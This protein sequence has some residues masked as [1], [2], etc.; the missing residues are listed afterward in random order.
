MGRSGTPGHVLKLLK[1]GDILI[2]LP[3][4]VAELYALLHLGEC[5]LEHLSEVA[6]NFVYSLLQLS[7]LFILRCYHL[8]PLILLSLIQLVLFLD[9]F[10][11]RGNLFILLGNLSEVFLL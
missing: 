5:V 2:V 9:L 11:L 3:G 10:S 4:L 7:Y 1:Y 8:I 6:R